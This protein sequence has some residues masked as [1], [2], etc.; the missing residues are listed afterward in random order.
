M[1]KTKVV[2]KRQISGKSDEEGVEK[3]S[4]EQEQEQE[5]ELASTATSEFP[6]YSEEHG[7]E[8]EEEMIN[9]TLKWR[10]VEVKKWFKIVSTREVNTVYGKCMIMSLEDINGDVIEAWATGLIRV[11]A[12]VKINERGDD[13][14]TY[15][16]SLGLS[17]NKKGSKEYY[18]FR[19]NKK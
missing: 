4:Q 19:I 5:K 3:N 16:I 13:K 18:D 14:S 12:K 8:E 7:L 17:E 9:S 1:A 6:V 15:I 10:E 11:R 2:V